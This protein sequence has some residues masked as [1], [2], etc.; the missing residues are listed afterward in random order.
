[1]MEIAAQ[2]NPDSARIAGAS[3]WV[4]LQTNDIAGAVR[5][6]KRATELAPYQPDGWYYL[7]FSLHQAGDHGG[8][9]AA[10]DKLLEIA[11]DY[12]RARETR[13]IAACEASGRRDCFRRR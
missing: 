12:P 6:A 13:E 9:L 1:M 8:E 2:G 5:E 7:A 11:P 3:A 10:I 4:L